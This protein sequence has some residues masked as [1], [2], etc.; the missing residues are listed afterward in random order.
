MKAKKILMIIFGVIALAINVFIIVEGFIGVE[1]SA[2]TS[3]GF[4]DALIKF[5]ESINPASHIG[6]N[7]EQVHAVV[8]KLFGHF[9]LFGASGLFT[10][11]TFLMID[12]VMINRKLETSLAIISVGLTVAVSSELAQL[13]SPGRFG[14]FTDV[15]IDFAGFIV[16]FAITFLIAYLINNKRKVKME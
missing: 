2:S 16:F 10:T 9:F 5:V 8:R 12:D 11:L 1:K 15:L 14:L 4:T 6:D 13:F 3:I 7:K